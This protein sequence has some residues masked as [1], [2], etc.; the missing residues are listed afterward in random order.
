MYSFLLL[1]W[2]RKDIVR[3]FRSSLKDE[4]DVHSR[5]M[6]AYREVPWWWFVIVGVVSFAFFCAAIEIF[7]TQLPIWAAVV[8][9]LI[10]MCLSLPLAMLQAITNQQVPTQIMMELIAGYMLPGRP[11]ANIC[12]K[13][14]GYITCAQAINF[15]GDLKLGH[16]MKIPPRVMFSIQ[17]VAASVAAIWVTLLQDWMLN[18]IVDICSRTQPSGFVCPGSNTFATASVIW[19][20]IGP[21]RLFSPGAPYSALLW[22]FL[23]GILAPIPFYFLARRFPLSFYR[24]INIPVFFAGLGAMPPA[25]GINYVSWVLWGF[26]FNFVVR[27]FH[28]RWWMRYNYILSAALDSGFALSLL[29][30]FFAL[31]LPKPGGIHFEWW[32]NT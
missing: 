16:Y 4:R 5:L 13:T 15:A 22:F 31:G 29:I 28:F 9:F 32:G 17:L 7:P 27:R 8:G 23:I 30:I 26:V 19:G 2:F 11:F 3:R 6:L 21:R 10:A 24:Y 12:F 18:N 14:L 25:S 1:V 20:A